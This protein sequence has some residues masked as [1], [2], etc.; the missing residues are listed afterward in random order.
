MALILEEAVKSAT[1]RSEKV[2]EWVSPEQLQQRLDLDLGD[3]GESEEKLLQRC[4]DVIKYSVKTAHPR[5]FN[6]LYGGM[7]PY[8]T[9]ASFITEALKPSIYTY[10]VAPVFTLME[11]VVL[12]KL[13]EVIGWKDGDGIFNAGGS[14]SNMYAINLARFHH[15]PEI[16]ELGMSACPR[17]VLFSS[18]ECH[19]SI[20]KAA[21]F[22]GIGT[23]NVYV[24]PSDKRGKMIPSSLEELIL[25]AK[26]EGAR[27]FMVNATAG[28][29]VLGAF[30]PIDQIVAIC[31]KYRLWLHVD[32]CWGGAA[33][34]S[35]KHSHLVKGIH[36]ANSVAWNQH[37]MMMACLQCCVFVVRD[38]TGLL[39]HCYSAKAAY[40]FQQDKFYDVSFDCGDKSIQCSRKPDAFKIWL[41]WKALGTSRLGQRVERA[42]AMAQYLTQQIKAQKGF[43]LVMEP[44]Y[45]NVCFWYVPPRLRNVPDSADFWNKL[46][47]VAPVIKERMVKRG[48]L[49]VGYQTHKDKANFFRMITISPQVTTEDMD[50]VL[51][52][53]HR[54]GQD[55]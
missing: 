1:D 22:L 30:D 16:K 40:L 20:T 31:E 9:A 11:K 29:T 8:S 17:L 49:M 10:E 25:K 34:L 23:S 33:L 45:A 35:K 36:R 50:F 43:R 41:L 38:Q 28:T 26:S 37:K 47:K 7:E 27:P 32:A 5:F 6:Q 13:I 42:L 4:R 53:I 48:S 2:C 12:K 51:D 18:Q 54:L 44:E 21:A 14:M 24:V 15:C 39:Q 55:L 19:Y 3:T 52:E 46:H